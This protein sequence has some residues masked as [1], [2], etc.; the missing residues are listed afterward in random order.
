[1]KSQIRTINLRM[2]FLGIFDALS[3]QDDDNKKSV[4]LEE[5]LT[6]KEIYLS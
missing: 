1:M 3:K 6:R 2:P 4:I 5:E